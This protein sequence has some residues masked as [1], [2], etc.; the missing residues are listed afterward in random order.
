MDRRRKERA[1]HQRFVQQIESGLTRLKQELA[2]ACKRKDRGA[3]ERRIGRLLGWNTRAAR[4]FRIDLVD[5]ITSPSGLRLQWSRIEA[6]D[7]WAQLSEGCYLLR[8]NL[9]GRS[10]EEL[11]RRYM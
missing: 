10:P 1:I 6:W 5:D 4:A 8:T 11:W 2:R 7:Q 3:I 9:T